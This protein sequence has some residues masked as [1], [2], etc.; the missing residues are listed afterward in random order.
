MLLEVFFSNYL[1]N[2]TGKGDTVSFFNQTH[3]F[4]FVVVIFSVLFQYFC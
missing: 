2:A 4:K 1:L 3:C